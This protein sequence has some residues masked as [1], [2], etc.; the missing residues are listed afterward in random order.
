[1]TAP[2]QVIIDWISALGWDDRQETGYPLVAG[3]YLPDQPDR[4]CVITGGG[5][6][7]YLTEE[8][9]TDGSLFQARLRGPTGDQLGVESAAQLLDDLIL[10]AHFPAAIDGTVINL[11]ARQ[12]SGPTPLP[13]DPSD[14]RVDFTSNYLIVTGV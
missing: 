14:Q 2:T 4:L 12:G 11:V 9:A 6:P 13:W 1:M 10:G 3:P 5:G 8:P 7:G